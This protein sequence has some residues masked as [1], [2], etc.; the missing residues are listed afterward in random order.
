MTRLNDLPPKVYILLFNNASDNTVVLDV[1]ADLQ[2]ANDECLRQ[3]ELADVT[4]SNEYSTKGPDGAH[5]SPVEPVRWDT[6][7]GVCCWV[8]AFA[9]QPRRVVVNAMSDPGVLNWRERLGHWVG[10]SSCW[11]LVANLWWLVLWSTGK[12]SERIAS[13][14]L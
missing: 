2:D 4:L 8:E 14:T 10:E 9:V 1:F 6:A 12:M 7:E 11:D 3:A 13:D 5:Q